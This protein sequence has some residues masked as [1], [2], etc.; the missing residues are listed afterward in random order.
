[1]SEARLRCSST[2]ATATT[3]GSVAS[4]FQARSLSGSSQGR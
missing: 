1:M 3:N 2:K 4:V